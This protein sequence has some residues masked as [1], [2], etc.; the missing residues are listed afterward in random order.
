MCFKRWKSCLQ[1]SGLRR[2]SISCLPPVFIISSRAIWS[3]SV[4][5][6][7]HTGFLRST[8]TSR[9]HTHHHFPWR[10]GNVNGIDDNWQYYLAIIYSFQ[11]PIYHFLFFLRKHCTFSRRLFCFFILISY[12]QILIVF[13]ITQRIV[14]VCIKCVRRQSPQLSSVFP[15]LS[16]GGVC[17]FP[18]KISVFHQ[19]VSA[20]D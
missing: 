9:S 16:V 10:R 12:F 7:F 3:R 1:N 18:Y 14:K 6:M 8:V 2:G 5:K 11:I 13:D 4:R 19:M 15:S 20:V 17:W